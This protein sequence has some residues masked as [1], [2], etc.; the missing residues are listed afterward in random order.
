MATL[1]NIRNRSGLLLAVIGIA[2]L[3]FI[4]GDFL[5]ST[6]SNTGNLYIGNVLGND[7]LRQTYNKKVDAVIVK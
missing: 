2:M 7:I 6:N 3:A 1:G 4:L 5:K